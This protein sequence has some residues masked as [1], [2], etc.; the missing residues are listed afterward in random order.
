M[1]V[2]ITQDDLVALLGRPLSKIEVDNFGLYLEIAILRL[3]DLLCL[4]DVSELD[5]MPAD[6]MLVLA[7]IF[8]VLS[9]ESSEMAANGISQRRVEDFYIT[10]D[11]NADDAY[12]NVV[13]K[14][15]AITAKYSKCGSGI[16]H[17]RTII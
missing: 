17:G 6:L 14:N 1:N 8:G 13:N 9:A 3:M 2:V 12:T 15:S 16:R 7:R 11:N 5:D 10:Y 4:K